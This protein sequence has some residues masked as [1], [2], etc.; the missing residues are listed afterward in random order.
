MVAIMEAL[1]IVLLFAAIVRIAMYE[2]SAARIALVSFFVAEYLFIRFCATRRWYRDAPRWSGIELHFK[3]AM[4]PTSYILTIF[5]AALLILPSIWIAAA[6]AFLLA[7]VAHV[8]VILLYFHMRDRGQIAPN[9][10]S[11]GRYLHT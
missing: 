9:Y 10:Y 3:K 4:V 8:D 6:A 11:S 2:F 7:V 5:G 1:G